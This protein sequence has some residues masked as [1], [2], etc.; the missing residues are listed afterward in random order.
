MSAGPYTARPTGRSTGA[1]RWSCPASSTSTRIP[2]SEPMNKGW[3]DEIGIAQAVQ[4]LAL[5]VHADLPRR[6]GGRARP[7]SRVA[8]SELLMSGVTTLVDLSVAHDGWLD[9]HG[10]KRHARRARADV[11]LGALVHRER[12][13]RR[14]TNG[15]RAAGEKRDGRPRIDAD[16]RGR[17]QHPSRAALRHGLAV[18]D[19]HLHGR[20]DPGDSYAR[21][22]A[23]QGCPSR[24]TPRRASSNST[25]SP[26][27]TA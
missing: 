5:R 10:G 6:C 9:L 27:A 17:Q 15:T 4:L 3:N 11:P 24:S 22:A 7:A 13:S 19:R 16:R 25:R 12:P 18:A 26:A 2:S 8:L 20:A 1:A 23:A 21:G 14:N